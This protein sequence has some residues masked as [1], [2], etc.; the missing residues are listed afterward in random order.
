MNQECVLSKLWSGDDVD[1]YGYVVEYTSLGKRPIVILRVGILTV[2]ITKLKKY[3]TLIHRATARFTMCRKSRTTKLII[4]RS[5]HA[6][7]K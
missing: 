7:Q 3:V 2:V 6:W 5:P 4:R 1:L